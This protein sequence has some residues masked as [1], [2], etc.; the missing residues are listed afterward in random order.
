M[1]RIASFG[2]DHTRL[3][4]GLYV[5]R[6]DS[7]GTETVTTFDVRLCRPNLEPALEPAAAHT[8]EHIVATL[9][10]NDEEIKDN[11]V[12]WGPM[13]CMTG[14]YLIVKG[15]AEPRDYLAKL[16]E[17]FGKVS[18]W[19]DPIPGAS[20]VECGNYTF[21][22]ISGARV[23]ATRYCEVLRN[24]GQKNLNYPSN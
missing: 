23:A 10:R 16:I 5:S 11:I 21:Q 15:A 8:I 20:A 6:R 19:V 2:V 24:A 13:G 9:L 3:L 1:E 12:Y 18:E 14:F 4:P 22:N 17:V 7:L